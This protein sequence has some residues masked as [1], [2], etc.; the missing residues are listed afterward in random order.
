MTIKVGLIGLGKIGERHLNAWTSLDGA[1]VRGLFDVNAKAAEHCGAKNR[2][3][4][5]DSIAQ[6]METDLDVV[7][8]CV[9]TDYHHEIILQALDSGKHVFCEKPLTYTMEHARNIKAKAEETGKLVMVGYLY[10]FHP[11]FDLFRKVMGKHVIGNPYYATFRIGGRG[12]HRA[13]KH[14]ANRAGGA[15]FDML[16]HMIDLA[17]FYFGKPTEV[18]PLYSDIVLRERMI[19]NEKVHVDAEDCTIVRMRTNGT[20]IL[21]QGD[22]I[23]P[24][25]VNTVEI[26]G[27]NG[28]F[29]G[30]IVPRF[31]TTLYC[32]EPADIYD[33]G[34]N[35]F[36]FPPTNL[37]EKELGRFV[38]CIMGKAT[39]TNTIDESIAILEITEEIKRKLQL[40]KT[41][42]RILAGQEWE[43]LNTFMARDGG[44][45]LG[46]H[47][48]RTLM[49]R[50]SA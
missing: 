42:N 25:F 26:H 6:L 23:T 4:V 11:S 18:E 22:L 32:N 1:E 31:P 36:Q 19:D 7:D 20:Q 37:I 35:L 3:R 30:S 9:P 39:L 46:V 10:R 24:S 49:A 27:D 48:L 41:L 34:E 5:F 17:L 16:T 14:Q 21:L 12:G 45:S 47:A 28:S 38:D 2:V 33:R 44:G 43:E 8:V 50:R 15:T 29:F 13:W 40:N